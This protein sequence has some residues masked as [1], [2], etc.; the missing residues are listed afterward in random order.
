MKCLKCGAKLIGDAKFCSYCGAKVE[1]DTEM[2]PIPETKDKDESKSNKIKEKFL[3]YW[4]ELSKFGKFVTIGITVFAILALVAFLAGRIV[5]G[6]LSIVQIAI[7]VAAILMKK[8]IIKVPQSW[9]PIVAVVASFVLIIPYFRLFKINSADYVKYDWDAVVLADMLPE[10]ESP[11]GE[12]IS[13][14][15]DYLSLDVTKTSTTQ[16]KDYIEACKDKGFTIDTEV[17]GSF[18][19]AYNDKGYKLSLSHYDYNSEMH[20]NLDSAM[21]METIIWPD[22]EMVMLLP[23]PKS[24]TG[25]I[26]NNDEDGFSVYI[27]NTTIDDYNTY[28]KAC[29]KKGFTVDAQKK[30]KTFSAKNIDS[31][32][33]SVDYKGNNVIYISVT[34]PEFDVTVEVECV[35]NWIFSKY[36]VELS[37]DDEFEGTI[38]HGDK[39]TFEV[40]LKRGKHTISFESAEDDTLDGEVEVEITKNE[41]IKLKISCSSFGVDV[42]LLS[43]TAPKDEDSSKEATSNTEETQKPADTAGAPDV[44]TN[45]LEKHYEEVKKQFED[46]GFT[47]VTCVAH[48]IDFNEENVFEG[49]VVNIAVGEEAD[50]CTFEKG[51]QWPKDIKIR[52]DYRV[53]PAKPDTTKIVLPQEDS[54]LGK[55]LDTKGTSTVYYINTDNISNKPST[56]T[57]GSATVTDGVAEYL[58]YL[59]DLGFTVTV[60]DT[61]HKEPYS[62]YHTYETDF[63][64]SNASV[65]WTMYLCIQKEQYVEYELDVHLN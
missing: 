64:V 40:V 50:I 16:Y 15:E 38:P 25:K 62:G 57:W 7:V 28:V 34:E 8:N 45:L 4:N 12:I 52:I 10:P 29:E 21:E 13:N 59:K 2:P 51:E 54:K 30:D 20:I 1:E 19:Y 55:D 6:I 49:S 63:K 33:L 65:S 26:Y 43:E 46:A 58:D 39:K 3:E 18:F 14:S 61:T 9:I 60:T 27:G 53:K 36:D 24:T 22:S 31:Y 56:T 35:E 37:I 5:A 32:K 44:W 17:T 42:E 23:V 47:N 11:Y 48:E 41:T